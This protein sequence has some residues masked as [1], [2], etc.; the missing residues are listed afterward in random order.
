MLVRAQALA[1]RLRASLFFVPMA[2]VVAGVVLGLVLVEVDQ[3]LIESPGDLPFVLTSTVD[4]SRAVLGTIASATITVA[5]IAFS[6]SLLVIQLASS[7]YSPRVV[8]GLL[9]DRFSKRVMGVV[10]GTFTYCLIVLRSVR[11]PLEEDGTPVIPNLSVTIAVVF[12]VV[13]ILSIVAFID[14]SA[15][16]MDV[17]RLLGDASERGVR[18]ARRIW[19]D[20]ARSEPEAP[21]AEPP[22]DHLVVTH[23]TGGWVQHIALDAVVGVAPPGGTVRLETEVGRYAVV[24]TPL[25]AVWP[26][27]DDVDEACERARDA[28]VTGA[29]R[30]AEQDVGYAV[31]Q[32]ADVAL[33]ALSPSVNDPTTAQ[34]AMFNAASVLGELLER[35]PP[36]LVTSSD[37]ERSLVRPE[38]LDHADVIAIAFDEVRHAAAGMPAVAV[39]LLEV[40]HLLDQRAGS[41]PGV[42]EALAH[43]AALIR[44]AARRADLLP[45]DVRR[46]EEAHD[47]RF[48]EP[49]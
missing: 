38:R 46:V 10:V 47:R 11:G 30:T 49:G 28:V 45:E 21:L 8:H 35:R 23:A 27:P 4:S 13:A 17:S 12:G 31:R 15:H 5:G 20:E 32:L 44:A 42:H 29:S 14:H 9:R 39:Y 33:R 2:F 7:Q 48:G 36:P 22:A 43:Q 40:L 1:E 16:A 19:R 37:G 25:C 6:I 3:E 26:V 34:D 24:G 18:N 41:D